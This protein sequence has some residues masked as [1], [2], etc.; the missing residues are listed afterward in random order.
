MTSDALP[1]SLKGGRLTW[2]GMTRLTEQVGADVRWRNLTGCYV[3]EDGTEIRSFPGWKLIYDL[4]YSTAQ[5]YV[6]GT[7]IKH[8]HGFKFFSGGVLVV[9]AEDDFST[10]TTGATR[11]SL[12]AF[13]TFARGNISTAITK[14]SMG[15]EVANRYVKN[16]AEWN[17]WN[18]PL[19]YKLRTETLP[20]RII[21]TS[22]GY[23]VV[24]QVFLGGLM[25]G[26]Q[27]TQQMYMP[28]CLGVPKAS[29][30]LFESGPI[31]STT[32]ESPMTTLLGD[33]E[34]HVRVAFRDEMTGETGLASEVFTFT[35][36][37][38]GTPDKLRLV[39]P[40][41]GEHTPESLAI[42]LRI[43]S[44]R[45][46]GNKEFL[47]LVKEIPVSTGG[48]ITDQGSGRGIH[49]RSNLD[50]SDSD[51][52]FDIPPPVIPQ[53]PVGCKATQ[54]VRGFTFFGGVHG[55]FGHDAESYLGTLDHRTSV[56]LQGAV[57]DETSTDIAKG[58]GMGGYNFPSGYAGVKLASNDFLTTRKSFR[59]DKQ[60]NKVE[61]SNVLTS[62]TGEALQYDLAPKDLLADRNT[63]DAPVQMMPERGVVRFSEEANPGVVPAI[64]RIFVDAPEGEDVEALGKLGS[65]LIICTRTST[66]GLGWG[67]TP[68]GSDPVPIDY[69]YGCIAPDSMVEYDG[70]LAWLSDKGP[71][72]MSGGQVFWAGMDLK[73]HFVGPNK[74]YKRDS[75]GM[76]YHAWARHDPERSLVYFGVRQDRGTS[77]TYADLT[78]TI[79]SYTI[80][81]N[82]IVRINC[83]G[84]HTLRVGDIVFIEGINTSATDV[85]INGFHRVVE[86][87][88]SDTFSIF[89]DTGLTQSSPVVLV[90]VTGASVYKNGA[91]S[92]VACDTLL[93]W[94]YRANAWS[95]LEIPVGMEMVDM[96]RVPLSDGEWRMAF[97][98]TDGKIYA[99]DDASVDTQ[100]GVILDKISVATSTPTITFT[101]DDAVQT[102]KMRVGMHFYVI[103]GDD[104]GDGGNADDEGVVNSGTITAISTNTI[105]V[106]GEG[107]TAR[108]GDEVYVGAVPMVLESNF[109]PLGGTL[110]QPVRL[111][112]A[113]VRNRYTGPAPNLGLN[114]RLELDHE[115][116]GKVADAG[117]EK[118]SFKAIRPSLNFSRFYQGNA[119]GRETK[120][121]LTVHGIEQFAIQD[122]ELEIGDA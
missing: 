109:I 20:D 21:M 39:I 110:K 52:D 95:I 65:S 62:T 120:I 8:F 45:K 24:F 108:V 114:E 75:R 12:V 40:L 15:W 72:A 2:P 31:D 76:M 88:D 56:S 53:M 84:N 97:M 26:A 18:W 11:D 77:T 54:T 33:G 46:D 115:S 74:I 42:S 87:V 37:S 116:D 1:I 81:T 82:R 7:T 50:W 121:T 101:F 73:D 57:T 89:V 48:I 113:T 106:T 55:D 91:M 94:S 13:Y 103:R 44:S 90:T 70:G 80:W 104:S 102:A 112:A 64:N 58:Y 49:F 22:P 4:N 117:T 86:N 59:L 96:Q 67:R 6:G 122:I 119:R 30:N 36:T 61:V 23:S 99:F 16:H 35:V 93:I 66:H 83:S 92:K 118:G 47:G 41:A 107:H 10:A 78:L 3:S 19:A 25:L 14:I 34:Y 100:S 9:F 69:Q 105:T 43:Y 28:R 85:F 51:I 32:T 68:A 79:S 71:V 27:N 60:V 111:T 29:I 5:A 63:S 98:T 38:G 17:R